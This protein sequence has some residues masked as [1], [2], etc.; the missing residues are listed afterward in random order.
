MPQLQGVSLLQSL[1]VAAVGAEP[2][3]GEGH[4][5]VELELFLDDSEG[6]GAP[7]RLR[8]GAPTPLGVGVA[9]TTD[10]FL[11]DSVIH[12]LDVVREVLGELGDLVFL[13]FGVLPTVSLG[14]GFFLGEGEV[15][16]RNRLVVCEGREFGGEEFAVSVYP[17]TL[18]DVGHCIH[19]FYDPGDKGFVFFLCVLFVEDAVLFVAEADAGETVGNGLAVVREI[20]ISKTTKTA[21]RKIHAVTILCATR[22]RFIN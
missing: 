3:E 6:G 21:Y 9:R 17:A 19:V 4:L 7:R 11:Q 20:N 12:I 1:V 15:F 22:N 14:Q 10:G 13:D 5:A 18:V 2:G 8:V 16:L